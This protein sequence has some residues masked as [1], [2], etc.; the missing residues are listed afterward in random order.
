MKVARYVGFENLLG[1]QH[2]AT[3]F[4]VVREFSK[5]LFEEL[6]WMMTDVNLSVKI[7]RKMTPVLAIHIPSLNRLRF[8]ILILKLWVVV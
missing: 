4:H 2:W 7:T 8:Y 6:I 1:M 5:H 3:L